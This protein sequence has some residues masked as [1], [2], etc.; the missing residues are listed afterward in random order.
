MTRRPVPFAHAGPTVFFK[1]RGFSCGAAIGQKHP[2][3]LVL[4]EEADAWICLY[5]HG[6]FIILRGPS[7]SFVQRCAQ[8]VLSAVG[9]PIVY[10][11]KVFNKIGQK[12]VFTL[13][14]ALWG[15]YSSSV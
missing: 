7:L 9:I 15:V 14:K 10:K 12:W 4:A 3:S 5:S 8:K 6:Q 13:V 1:R 2:V 11:T